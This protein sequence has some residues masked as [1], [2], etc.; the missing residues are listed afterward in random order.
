MA[1]HA[2]RTLTERFDNMEESPV[3][4]RIGLVGALIVALVIA[5]A[6]GHYVG[7]Y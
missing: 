4:K 3:L 1:E 6:L 7:L 2:R 5:L